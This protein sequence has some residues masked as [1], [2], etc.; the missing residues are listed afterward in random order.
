MRP[1]FI[2]AAMGLAA[3]VLAL[4]PTAA[5]DACPNRGQLDTLYC[6]ADERS[7]RRRAD[8]PG[9]AARTHRRWSGPIRRSRTP[10]STP[11]SSSR[12]PT[13]S[14]QC[15]G[16]THRLLSRAVELGRDRGDALGPAALRRLLDRPDGFA[17]NLAGAVPFAAK[18]TRE[19]IRGY[20]LLAIVKADSP[21]Q[22]LADLKGKKVAHTSP[23]SNSGNLAP[24]VLFPDRGPEA[25]RR[26]QAA[27]VGRARQVGARRRLAATTTWPPSPP[28]CSSA[29][30]RAARSRPRT[31]ASST[32]A[33]C[34]RPRRSPTPTT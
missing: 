6:D 16:K 13:T 5:Q 22:K 17:V 25:R 3:T 27:D 28:T 32:R 1:M 12:S 19:G 24:R 20:N 18:G 26:L 29:W 14:T 15:T 30:S 10:P 33:R 23:S 8:G 34:S 31:S 21:Y 11:T 4:Y 2:A 7:R 9:Q